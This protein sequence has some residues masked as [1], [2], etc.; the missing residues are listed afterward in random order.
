MRS[1]ATIAFYALLTTLFL[2]FSATTAGAQAVADHLKCYKV[3]DP[4]AKVPYTA[5]LGGLVAE[6]GCTIKVPAVMVC[7]PATKTN[8]NPTP[9]GGGATGT[10]NA[11]GCYKIKCPKTTLPALQLNDQFGSRS[12]TPSAPKLLCAPAAPPTTTTTTT[13]TGSTTSTT[14]PTCANGGIACGSPCGR[15][16][17]GVCFGASSSSCSYVHCGSAAPVCVAFN[18]GS[19]PCSSDAG[20]AAGEVCAG[21][22]SSNCGV[23]NQSFCDGTCPE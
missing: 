23:T 1:T 6:P 16:C 13:T 18:L 10:P 20:C 17:T 2:G 22:G 15:A 7:V 14:A 12:V 19:T 11:F 5:D 8:V 21:N 9:P 4:Q 3:K